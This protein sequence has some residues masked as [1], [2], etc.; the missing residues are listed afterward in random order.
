MRQVSREAEV[1]SH[2]TDRFPQ[3]PV[4]RVPAQ[5]TDVHDLAGL[6]TIGLALAGG[7]SQDS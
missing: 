5:P 1:A 2:F 6:R 3:V 7:G 4:S